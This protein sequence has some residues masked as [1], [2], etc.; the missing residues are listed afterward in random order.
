MVANNVIPARSTETVVVNFVTR[1]DSR[2]PNL[3][4]LNRAPR[5]IAVL[6]RDKLLRPAVTER[7]NMNE[8]HLI[9]LSRLIVCC[10]VSVNISGFPLHTF[11]DSS[12]HG[13]NDGIRP[14]QV[15]P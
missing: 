9:T 4:I 3:I 13:H 15:K 1:R 14:H 7:E 8:D 11:L 2:A 5:L 10:A 12:V 6:A